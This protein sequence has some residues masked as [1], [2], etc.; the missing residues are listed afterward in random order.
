PGGGDEP[1]VLAQ[2]LIDAAKAPFGVVLGH[3]LLDGGEGARR[4]A[5]L[6]QHVRE[7][8][9]AGGVIDPLLGGLGEVVGGE[10]QRVGRLEPLEAR[11]VARASSGFLAAMASITCLNVPS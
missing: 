2:N 6:E 9:V 10:L 7:Q 8:A 11:A 4:L 3:A 1:R 5:E